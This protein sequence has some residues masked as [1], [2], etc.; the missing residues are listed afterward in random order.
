MRNKILLLFVFCLI[1]KPSISYSLV[2]ID[3]T[4]GNLDPLP[5]AVSP[6][7]VEPGSKD[8]SKEG[9][10]IKNIGEEIS[11][12]IEINFKRSGLFNPLKNEWTLVWSMDDSGS[13]ATP[14][15]KDYGEMTTSLS[16]VNY[17]RPENWPRPH[18]MAAS[19]ALGLSNHGNGDGWARLI[20]TSVDHPY[21]MYAMS[22]RYDGSDNA[23]SIIIRTLFSSR[24]AWT[25]AQ[26]MPLNT[27]FR[28]EPCCGSSCRIGTISVVEHNNN[29]KYSF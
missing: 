28:Y 14:T 13:V 19:G 16:G 11:K 12:V 8:I 17:T 20:F 26:R 10:I 24:G 9:K 5:I 21:R 4:R 18:G 6:L 25:Q 3:I 7:Y 27:A 29:I 15:L 22:N 2:E 1:L 23:T